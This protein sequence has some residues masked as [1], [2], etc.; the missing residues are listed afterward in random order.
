[1]NF[2]RNFLLVSCSLMLACNFTPPSSGQETEQLK[3]IIQQLQIKL[4]NCSQNQVRLTQETSQQMKI[5]TE[6]QK[7]LDNGAEMVEDFMLSLQQL[8]S[9][10]GEVAFLRQQITNPLMRGEE[11]ATEIDTKKALLETI[12]QHRMVYEAT[13]AKL[14]K[15]EQDTLN[16]QKQIRFMRENLLMKDSLIQDFN[17]EVAELSKE[18]E[19][20]KEYAS[21]MKT[22]VDSI[23]TSIQHFHQDMMQKAV[24]EAQ[25]YFNEG[26]RSR[27]ALERV[28][29]KKHKT[30]WLR[31]ALNKYEKAEEKGHAGAS[32]A[33]QALRQKYYKLL[34]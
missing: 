32:S 26:E 4:D 5:I 34:R 20:M 16:Q 3:T 31:E 6:Q 22:V 10:E 23:I 33:A 12:E 1:M 11:N 29:R 19:E 9:I 24:V 27:M 7:A 28:K 14:I 15:L 30:F 18:N 8:A 21:E 13:L 17:Q 2:L 25:D